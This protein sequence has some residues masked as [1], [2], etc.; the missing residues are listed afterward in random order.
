MPR[1]FQN[2]STPSCSNT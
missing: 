1:I 2:I